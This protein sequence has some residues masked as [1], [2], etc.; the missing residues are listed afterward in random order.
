MADRLKETKECLDFVISLG[1]ALAE[2]LSDGQLDVSDLLTLWEPISNVSEAIDGWEKLREEIA[3]L[4]MDDVHHLADY[5]Q[6]EFD[7]EDDRIEKI[8]EDGLDTALSLLSFIE[9]LKR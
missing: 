2:S 3:N 6:D 4:S 7:I 5:V 1:E 8:I 9:R